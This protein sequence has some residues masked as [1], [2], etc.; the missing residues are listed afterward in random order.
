MADDKIST[1]V[2][3]NTLN[4]NITSNNQVENNTKPVMSI[5]QAL[6]NTKS[7]KE[8]Q[9]AKKVDP[10]DL[11]KKKVTTKPE[12][13]QNTQTNIKEIEVLQEISQT[14][15]SLKDATI[16]FKTEVATSFKDISPDKKDDKNNKELFS[17]Y[18]SEGF[19]ESFQ[20]RIIQ[21]TF[22]H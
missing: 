10:T 18:L 4:I 9:D 6:K 13:K 7:V 22:Q 2:N 17:S 1:N 5:N 8:I 15:T 3:D 21:R 12:D 19:I 20:N 14:L 16:N 11:N